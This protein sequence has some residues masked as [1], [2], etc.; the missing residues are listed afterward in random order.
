MP[1]K[2]FESLEDQIFTI[3]PFVSKDYEELFEILNIQKII[4]QNI[5]FNWTKTQGFVDSLT[6][7]RYLTKSIYPLFFLSQELMKLKLSH[8]VK[9]LYIYQNQSCDSELFDSISDAFVSDYPLHASVS[10]LART[11]RIENP[12]FIY[13]VIQLPKFT[14]KN[15]DVDILKYEFFDDNAVEVRYL[16]GKRYVKRLLELNER[17]KVAD[18]QTLKLH[19][20]GAYLITGGMGGL[21]LLLAKYLISRGKVKVVLTGRSTLNKKQIAQIHDLESSGSKIKYIQTDISQLSEVNKLIVE[22]KSRFD[23]INGIIHCAGVLRDSF[24]LKQSKKEIGEVLAPKVNGIIYIDEILKNEKLDFFILFSSLTAVMGNI[25]QSAYAYANCFMDNFAY[26]RED[27]RAENRRFGKTI[28]IN[29]PL[30]DEGGMQVNEEIRQQLKQ[31]HGV[32][33]I[34]IK[35]GIKAFEDAY[36][37]S[38]PQI[39]VISGEGISDRDTLEKSNSNH[40]GESSEK[41]TDNQYF[42]FQLKSIT[43][44]KEIISKGI[45]ISVNKIETET[46]FEKYGIDSVTI[47]GLTSQL[48]KIFGELSKTLFFEYQNIKELSAYFIEN[49]RQKLIENI[50]EFHEEKSERKKQGVTFE[51]EAFQSKQYHFNHSSDVIDIDN[52]KNYQNIAIIGISGRYPQSKDIEEYWTNLQNGNDCIIEVPKER[53][54]WQQYY[55]E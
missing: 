33:A 46:P 21:G 51:E 23:R 11:I 4:P 9:L 34:S 35:K 13:K 42:D 25:G 22:I 54:D 19:T 16:D 27:L 50:F 14:S 52:P 5:V 7:D 37:I 12:K 55:T 36:K 28:A 44:I 47:M 1:G 17:S 48:E 43:F 8:E 10:G 53:W 3:N 31:N 20:D 30:W 32:S 15:F 26:V 29:W 39:A 41:F 49:H 45:K 18:L 38:I 24:I 40:N 2:S 6:L